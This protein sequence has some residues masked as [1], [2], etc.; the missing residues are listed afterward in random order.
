[1]SL[2]DQ[3]DQRI[4]LFVVI[5]FLLYKQSTYFPSAG[6]TEVR[7]AEEVGFVKGETQPRSSGNAAD[8]GEAQLCKRKEEEK[9]EKEEEEEEAAEQGPP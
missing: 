8:G 6:K 2:L 7:G 5:S 1:M 4:K 9:E 3:Q